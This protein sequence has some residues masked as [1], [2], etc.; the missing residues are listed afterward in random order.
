MTRPGAAA[1]HDI[2]NWFF[3]ESL[4]D[5]LIIDIRKILFSLA[6]PVLKRVGMINLLP[7]AMTHHATQ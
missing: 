4:G 7:H 3:G 1:Y 6:D 5:R 2:D